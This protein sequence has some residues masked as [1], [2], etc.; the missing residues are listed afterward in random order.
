VISCDRVRIERAEGVEA[1]RKFEHY[2]V[3]VDAEGLPQGVTLTRL[4]G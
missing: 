2:N 1:P 3:T 4:V